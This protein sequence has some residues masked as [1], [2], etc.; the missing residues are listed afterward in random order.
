MAGVKRHNMR[1]IHMERASTY[2]YLCTI[3][4]GGSVGLE[5]LPRNSWLRTLTPTLLLS[6]DDTGGELT[7]V[8]EQTVDFAPGQI[9]TL[10]FDRVKGAFELK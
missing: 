5:V 7:P 4:P 2:S 6:M 8:L 3:H 9:H 10:T 1:L